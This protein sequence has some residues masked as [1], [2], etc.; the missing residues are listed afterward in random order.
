M[1]ETPVE[2][3]IRPKNQGRMLPFWLDTKDAEARRGTVHVRGVDPNL[4]VGL[5]TR[6]QVFMVW[7]PSLALGGWCAI[8]DCEDDRGQAFRGTVPWPLI[9]HELRVARESEELSADRAQRLNEEREARMVREL[10]QEQYDATLYCGKAI[11]REVSGAG[12]GY[13]AQDVLDGYWSARESRKAPP[14]G[15]IISVGR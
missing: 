3:M 11:Q 2:Q 9:V 10:R 1:Y 5:D 13:S 7:G 14:R 15:Q 12:P 8:F 4:I 6:R